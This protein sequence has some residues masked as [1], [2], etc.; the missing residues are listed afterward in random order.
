MHSLTKTLLASASLLAISTLPAL[1]Q[2]VPTTP[3]SEHGGAGGVVLPP[4]QAPD[5]TGTTITVG[6][7]GSSGGETGMES[8]TV[9]QLNDV[10]SQVTTNASNIAGNEA[11]Q[12]TVNAAQ[13]AT[14]Q[15]IAAQIGTV[16]SQVSANTT[17][18]ASTNTELSGDESAQASVNSQQAATNTA[19]AAT[20]QQIT[21]TLGTVAT[22]TGANTQAIA[23]NEANQATENQ[24]LTSTLGTVSSQ[25]A[26]NTQGISTVSTNLGNYESA[27]D[28]EDT[29]LGDA[30]TSLQNQISGNET[31]QNTTNAGF[32]KD[33]NGIDNQIAGINGQL[34]SLN[35]QIGKVEREADAGVA[36]AMAVPSLPLLTPGKSWVGA[37]YGEYGGQSALGVGYAYQVNAHWNVGAGAAVP[38]SGNGDV[39]FKVQAGYE[40]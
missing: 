28:A 15:Q 27:Q 16:S 6:S 8:A 35:N 31:A 26:A 40:F 22:Q 25:T 34:T 18:I 7:T 33:I 10:Q 4:V 24:Q 12:Q 13:A 14:N 9:N 39:A 2:T 30:D 23:T 5:P 36:A 1:A 3:A 11:A 21:S 37:A 29:N 20:N 38:V 17:T 32:T 19:Q